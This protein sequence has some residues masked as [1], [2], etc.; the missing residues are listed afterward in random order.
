MAEDDIFNSSYWLEGGGGPPW[1]VDPFNTT[2]PSKSIARLGRLR[3]VVRAL[4]PVMHAGGKGVQITK[5]V[6]KGKAWY[7]S[8]DQSAAQQA[9][10]IGEKTAFLEGKLN[11]T[12]LEAS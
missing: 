4:R 5:P 2:A 11:S 10:R 9:K 6:K 1:A 3:G 8:L 12:Q 7:F